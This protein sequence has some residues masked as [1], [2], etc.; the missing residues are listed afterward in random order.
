MFA[1]V[2]VVFFVLMVMMGSWPMGFYH[3]PGQIPQILL[4]I[5]LMS[6]VYLTIFQVLY[7]QRKVFYSMED[8]RMSILR[9]QLLRNELEAER[10]IVLATRQY[11]HDLHYHGK[12]IYEFLQQNDVEAAKN[13][14][15]VYRDQL[16]E[17]T[18]ERYCENPAV[19]ALLRI[20]QRQCQAKGIDFKAEG[21]VPDSLPFTDPEIGRVLGNL[22][23]NACEA[24]EK[25]RNGFVH[26]RA[27]E[28]GNV[29]YVELRNSVVGQ[30]KFDDD[31]PRS[32]KTTGGIGISSVNAVL[33][34][35]DGMISF[36]QEGK[37]FLT[38]LILPL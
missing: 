9:T 22:L 38:R 33:A 34:K 7:Y 27:E 2:S 28:R 21:N 37:V 19:N 4:L 24:A 13:Y 14:L 25:T 15:K 31:V 6:M 35:Y 30:V 26:I 1:G 32:T 3:N 11:R 8:D 20:T 5:F 29:L 17:T 36:R 23:E 12:V 18:E 10:Q 16:A